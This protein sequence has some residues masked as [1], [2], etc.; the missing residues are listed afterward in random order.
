MKFFSRV[1]PGDHVVTPYRD[2]PMITVH[3]K[4]KVEQVMNNGRSYKIRDDSGHIHEY[5]GNIFFEADTYWTCVLIRIFS[6]LLE[7]KLSL[8]LP[9]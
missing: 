8:L 4:Y 3:K 7:V 6:R 9:K 5:N 1:E 2:R